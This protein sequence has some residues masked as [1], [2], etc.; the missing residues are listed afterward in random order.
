MNL[1]V[2]TPYDRAFHACGQ[3]SSDRHT[4]LAHNAWSDWLVRQ[5]ANPRLFLLRHHWANSTVLCA[6]VY[7]PTEATVPLFQELEAFKADPREWWPSDLLPPDRLLA[8][9]APL[10]SD[11][12]LPFKKA[13][14]DEKAAKRA[15]AEQASIEKSDMVRSLRRRGSTEIAAGIESGAVKWQPTTITGKDAAREQTKQLLEMTKGL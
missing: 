8:R 15:L 7:S 14:E 9:L 1:I 12:T 3:L 10:P 11:G 2:S 13:L 4:L 5:T 6:W